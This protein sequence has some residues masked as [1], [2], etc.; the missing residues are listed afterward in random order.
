VIS[1]EKFFCPINRCLLYDVAP[2]A[3]AVITFPWIAFSVF[4]G[5]DRA[6]CFEHRFAH[7]VLRRNEFKAVRLSGYFVIYGL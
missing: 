6:H 5:E 7:E 3:A 2:F 4:V 1:A